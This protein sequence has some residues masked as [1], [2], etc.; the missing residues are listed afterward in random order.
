MQQ[1]QTYKLNLIETSDAFSPS[2]LN[3][4]ME[5]VEGALAAKTDAA[6]TAALEQRVTVL[7]AHKCYLGSYVG[8]GTYSREI[9]LGF[10]PKAIL[11][12]NNT[13]TLRVEI[14]FPGMEVT[15][16]GYL[17]MALTS[18]GFHVAHNN[19][20][21]KFNHGNQKYLFLALA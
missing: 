18:N 17:L 4:N 2:P 11:I 3:E 6:D 20:I 16:D 19:Y 15:H 7:E 1:T 10:A 13:T 12:M 5:K 14:Y 21:D 9:D 8:D